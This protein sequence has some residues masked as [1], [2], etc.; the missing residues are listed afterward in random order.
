LELQAQ[1]QDDLEKWIAAL[2]PIL[3]TDDD[4]NEDEKQPDKEDDTFEEDVLHDGDLEIEIKGKAAKKHFWLMSDRF[5]FTNTASQEDEV[6]GAFPLTSITEVA[7]TPEGFTVVVSNRRLKFRCSAQDSSEWVNELKEALSNAQSR[8]AGKSTSKAEARS[9]SMPTIAVTKPPE[10]D[11]PGVPAKANDLPA[12]ASSQKGEG[13]SASASPRA[14]EDERT[15][16]CEGDLG[17]FR[18]GRV[19]KRFFMLYKDSFEYWLLRAD[20]ELGDERRGCIVMSDIAKL[21]S[22]DTGF[23]VYLV[24][25][26]RSLE[27]QCE[28]DRSRNEWLDTW[29][30]VLPASSCAIRQPSSQPSASSKQGTTATSGG[31]T[32]SGAPVPASKQKFIRW[33]IVS[34]RKL[35]VQGGLG[36]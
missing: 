33:K 4:D 12:S 35:V 34:E 19:E 7:A 20:Y 13:A 26:N 22:T 9:A 1:S 21:E 11:N 28:S 17:I 23:T 3:Q 5:E 27:L 32:G 14:S 6:Q 15:V 30:G 18:K 8:A 25:E 31:S 10:E 2:E 36:I 29:K 16:L 24:G